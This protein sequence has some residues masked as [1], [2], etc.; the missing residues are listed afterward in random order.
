[1]TATPAVGFLPLPGLG[2]FFGLAFEE[3]YAEEIRPG[4]VRSFPLLALAGGLLYRLDPIRL[5]PL[6]AGLLVIGAW[7]TC[8]YWRHIREIDPEGHRNVGL[9][10]P[11]C[12]VLAYLLG[13]ASFAEPPWV[14]I[15]VTAGKFLILTG[16]V[17]PFL[18]RQPVTTLTEITPHQV[19]LAVLAVCTVSY[20]SYLLQRYAAP[21]K[22][23]LWPAVLGGLYSSTA[24]TVVLARRARAEPALLR[25]M[26]VGH[27]PRHGDHVLAGIHHRGDVRPGARDNAGTGITG[28]GGIRP[29]ARPSGA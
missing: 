26:Q 28:I 18:P 10:T 9:M 12:N 11:L 14:A 19:W 20:A 23:G 22:G 7:L 16:L 5:F 6:T 3:F 4:G 21:R 8:H 13:P 15:G 27:H 1:M 2:S 17:L 29:R 25:Q 24:T